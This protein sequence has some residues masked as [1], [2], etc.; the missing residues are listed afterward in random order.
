[1]T[2]KEL[3]AA[4]GAEFEL[5]ADAARTQV[6]FVID[7]II[8]EAMTTGKS[9]FGKAGTFKRKDVKAVAARTNVPNALVPGK[10][11]DVA[12]KPARTKLSFELSKS[13]KLLGA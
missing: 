13:G 3:Y 12:A 8:E 2:E 6:E 11:Y 9:A 10:F 5:T 1:M 4:F 7:T